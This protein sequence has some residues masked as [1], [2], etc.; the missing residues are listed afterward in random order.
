MAYRFTYV[1]LAAFAIFGMCGILAAQEAALPDTRSPDL[2]FG[3]NRSTAG[4][5]A[6]VAI[7]R[8][9]SSRSKFSRLARPCHP[10][11]IANAFGAG[12]EL[13][14]NSGYMELART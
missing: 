13:G 14:R 11:K 6:T 1:L 5:P 2:G 12:P 10:A 4:G 3:E 8:T 9:Q 7:S